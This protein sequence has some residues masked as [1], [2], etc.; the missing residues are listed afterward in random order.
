[1][2]NDNVDK[3]ISKIFLNNMN[4]N[5]YSQNN[6]KTGHNID[7]DATKSSGSNM[8]IKQNS[9]L[10]DNLTIKNFDD[11]VKNGYNDNDNDND[12]AKKIVDNNGNNDNKKNHDKY[13]NKRNNLPIYYT[14]NS[15]PI[16]TTV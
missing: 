16:T 6:L 13:I 3:K 4:N 5:G 8:K 7:F 2:N 15:I 9:S 14:N 10:S 12:N 11:N 1:M